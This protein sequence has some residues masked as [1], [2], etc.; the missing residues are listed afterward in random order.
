MRDRLTFEENCA[1][2]A[3][4][5]TKIQKLTADLLNPNPEAAQ[6]EEEVSDL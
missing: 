4:L 5:R 6:T 2:L 3:Q 1:E